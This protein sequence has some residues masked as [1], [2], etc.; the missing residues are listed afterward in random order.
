MQRSSLLVLLLALA[1]GGWLL[2]SDFQLTGL[3][4]VTL[5]RRSDDGDRQQA[6]T[7]AQARDGGAI[8]LA[9]FN[10]QALG[11]TKAHKPHV[12][13]LLADIVRRF[14]V[15]AIQEIRSANQQ[16]LPGFVDQINAGEYHY[17]FVIGARQ[18]RTSSKEQYAFVFDAAS[19]Q[20]DRLA[21]YSVHD[22]HDLL[23]RPPLVAS[24]R[25]RG[26]AAERAFTFTLV[27]VHTDPD[28]VDA[29]VG[30]LAEVYQQVRRASGGEDDIILLGDLNADDRQLGTLGALPGVYCAI[31]GVATNTRG[32]EQYDNLVFHARSTTEFTGRAGVFDV[33]REFNLTMPQ[34]L[35]ISDHFPVWAEFS[36][37]EHGPG[38]PIA[39]RP[40]ATAAH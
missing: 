15:V 10:I 36:V 7:Q 13:E 26:V 4:Q 27:N 11:E 39:S 14:D 12:M 25:V 31:S 20:I 23:H 37:Y 18:G 35:E 5:R 33:M 3:D 30:A 9:S 1:G 24:F 40:E 16:L 38:G 32:T 21:C 6:H 22:P 29:E 28:E 34:A 19:V 17:D 8:R 2:L